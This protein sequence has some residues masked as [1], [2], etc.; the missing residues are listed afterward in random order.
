MRGKLDIVDFGLSEYA[1]IHSR[2]QEL[3]AARQ[4]DKA[5]DSLMLGEHSPVYTMG[6]R[7]DP[8][9][10]LQPPGSAGSPSA[11]PVVNIERGGDVTYHGPGQLVGYPIMR[12]DMTSEGPAWFVT[13]LEM[14]ICKLL[15]N[16]GL[17][18]ARDPKHRG[19][20]I[21]NDK[22]AA[23]GIR[24]SRSVSWHGFSLNVNP[25]LTPYRGIIPCGIRER[26]VT[27]MAG[28]GIDV[29]MQEIKSGIIQIFIKHF[30]FSGNEQ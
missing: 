20:W 21:G 30:G 13:Q 8:A 10:L 6:R 26:G 14:I 9:N 12:L 11:I 25:D 3:L 28:L 2:Q 18:P 27:S 22:I 24:I 4:A 5:N 15:E 1:V 7:A 23:I 16:Y 17:H 19:V 29:P